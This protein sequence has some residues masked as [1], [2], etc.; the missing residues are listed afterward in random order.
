ME[1]SYV[2]AVVLTGLIVVFIALI[3]LIFFVLGLGSFFVSLQNKKKVPAVAEPI[4][5]VPQPVTAPP[6]QEDEFFEEENN[7]EIVAVIAA[8]IAMMGE[9]ENK[10]YKIK[11]VRPVTNTGSRR[12]AWASAGLR[13]NTTPF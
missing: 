3:I 2:A 11:S 7:D 1:G 8:A 12:S 9:A 6:E 4:K 13:D 5:A 10:T